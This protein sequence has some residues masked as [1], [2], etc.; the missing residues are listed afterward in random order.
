M[1]EDSLGVDILYNITLKKK[2][3]REKVISVGIIRLF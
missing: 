3:N 1:K 2:K